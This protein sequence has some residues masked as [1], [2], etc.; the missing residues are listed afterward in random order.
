MQPE[1]TQA[2]QDT[3]PSTEPLSTSRISTVQHGIHS[4]SAALHSLGDLSQG[5]DADGV[6]G[7]GDDRGSSDEAENTGIERFKGSSSR[8]NK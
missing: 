4:L 3:A 6:R 5:A 1:H 7:I 8:A 2:F